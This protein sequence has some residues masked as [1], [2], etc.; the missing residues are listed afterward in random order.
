MRLNANLP[1]P[2]EAADLARRIAL[3]EREI[4]ATEQKRA[5]M[6]AALTNRR[7]TLSRLQARR[8]LISGAPGFGNTGDE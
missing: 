5:G 1:W 8:A 2:G 4:I 3:L 6:A 7:E